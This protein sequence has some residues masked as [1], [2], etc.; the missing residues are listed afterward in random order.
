MR[1][2]GTVAKWIYITGKREGIYIYIYLSTSI[3]LLDKAYSASGQGVRLPTVD[4][5][6]VGAEILQK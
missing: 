3:Q 1:L 5:L 6:C 4:G 2:G